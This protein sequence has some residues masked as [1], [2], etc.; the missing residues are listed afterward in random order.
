MKISTRI[1]LACLFMATLGILAS[2]GMVAWKSLNLSEKAMNKRAENQLVSIREIKRE[3]I[4]DYFNTINKQILTFADESLVTIS[5]GE[6][7]KAYN[8]YLAQTGDV[9][10]STL[11]SYY[12]EQ[13]A[14]TFSQMN[15][16]K[17]TNTID[18]YQQ[19]PL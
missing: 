16:G 5:I 15:A 19:L 4:K 11:P 2:G 8:N 7:T 1:I 6:F 12:Q 10:T 9:N 3:Q 17:K 18:K 14:T 13:F